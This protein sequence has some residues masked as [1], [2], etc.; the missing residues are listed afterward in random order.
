ML[1]K[2]FTSILLFGI[3]ISVFCKFLETFDFQCLNDE[4][5]SKVIDQEHQNSEV[6]CDGKT[7]SFEDCFCQKDYSIFESTKYFKPVFIVFSVSFISDISISLIDHL[8]YQNP[9]LV[10][11][12][13]YFSQQLTHTK[14]QI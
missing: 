6:P 12:D 4:F 10:F 13:L 7:H 2:I 9:E 3:S 11:S 1:R 14:L 5:I 8:E